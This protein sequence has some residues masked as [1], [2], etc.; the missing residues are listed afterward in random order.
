MAADSF[1]F[2]QTIEAD[3][4]SD[5]AW[6]TANA[7]PVTLSF[8]V[9]RTLTGTFGGAITN[10]AQDA[11]Y[12]FTYSVP[13]ASTW[14]KIVVTIPGDTAGTWVMSGNAALRLLSI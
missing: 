11:S 1:T 12:P 7:Q 9:N 8:W 14:T 4:V 5:F 10:V 6:G 2:Y 13:A 3:M